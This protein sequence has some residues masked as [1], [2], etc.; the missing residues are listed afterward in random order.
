MTL[1][2][3]LTAGT[4]TVGLLVLA[5]QTVPTESPERSRL[6]WVTDDRLR[7]PEPASWLM[8]RRTY[9]GWGYSPL[10]QIHSRNIA[11]LTPT[12]IF[13]TGVYGE[14]HQAPPIVNGDTMF[15]TT[16]SQVFALDAT[17]GSL[18][19]RYVR[20][21]P[22]DLSKA[23]PTNRGVA[24]YE[25]KVYVGT[26]DAH[27]VALNATSGH[28]VWESTIENYQLG[29]YITMAPLVANGKVMVGTSGGEQGTRG[30]ITALDARDGHSVWK[31]HTIPAPDEP[32]GDTWPDEA[33]QTGGG[34]VWLTGTFDPQA[35]LTYWGVGNPGPWM[36]D[37]RPGDNLY[38][39]STIALDADTGELRAHYQYH[40]NGSWDWDEASAPLLIPLQ[41]GDQHFSAAIH[42]GR[43]GYLW[44]LERHLDRL[45]FLKATPF[46]HQNVFTGLHPITGRPSYDPERIPGTGKR[47]EFCPSVGGARN[48][49]PEAYSPQTGYLYIPATNNLCSTMTGHPIDYVPGQRFAGAEFDVLMRDDSTHVSELQAWKI[50]TGEQAWTRGLVTGGNGA[51]LATGGSRGFLG[52]ADLRA[53]NATSGRVLWQMRT[54][55]NRTGVPTT[56]AVDGVQ[57]VAI[58]SGADPDTGPDDVSSA[59]VVWAFSVDCQC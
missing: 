27:V 57:Y 26:L 48:W 28:V 54:N 20:P 14:H 58:Q 43:N 8:Y 4:I 49:P 45:T 32:G 17:D 50:A 3:A 46:V 10:R 44:Y 21:L 25:D 12:W 5:P 11:D 22:P 30:S 2:Q 47:A 59:G 38:T 24:L 52:G 36:G 23:H 53:F 1:S 39:N 6:P 29:Y 40:W 55:A 19:W 7:N 18:R 16:A 33:W 56:Y 9:D 41:R 13:S 51:V 31:R 34:P 15:V 42:A 35:N 37:R